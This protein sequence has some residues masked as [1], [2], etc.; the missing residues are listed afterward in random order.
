LALLA[1]LIGL[2]GLAGAQALSADDVGQVISRVV[3]EA[4]ARQTPATMAVVDRVGAV[5]AVYS[6]TGAPAALPVASNAKGANATPLVD[7]LNGVS[8]PVTLQ[9]IAKA[10]TA[11]Y[12][13]SSNGNAFSTRTASQIVQDHFNPGTKFTPSGPLYGVQF[14]QL[15]CSD[16]NVA[17][18][19][20]SDPSSVTRGPHRSPLGLAGDPGGFPATTARST[21]SWRWPAA[22]GS[23]RRPRSA[24]TIFPPAACCCAIPTRPRRRGGSIR[25]ARRP[26]PACPA[27]WAGW[28]ASPAIMTPPT[29]CA[30]AAPGAAWRR[31][32][33]RTHRARSMPRYRPISWSM[34]PPTPVIR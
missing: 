32:S 20:G 3:Q 33:C 12:L 27:A 29:A 23:T 4:T 10:D 31:G 9:A 24:P 8:L 15:P 1:A 6:M 11:A 21:K 7:G 13:S 18:A 19:P 16:L 34:P 14:S 2:P 5:L 28:S 26:L 22:A 25:P 30:P 17:L